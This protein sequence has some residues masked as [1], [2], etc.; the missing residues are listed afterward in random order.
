MEQT[1]PSNVVLTKLEREILVEKRN[2][3]ILGHLKMMSEA[4]V[5]FLFNV[6]KQLIN[7]IKN[8]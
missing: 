1:Q 4:Q 2:E 6:S 7:Y 5:S 8:K 3:L